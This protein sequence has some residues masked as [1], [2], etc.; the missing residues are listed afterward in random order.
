MAKN[1]IDD[2]KTLLELITILT[3]IHRTVVNCFG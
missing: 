2:I 1:N 3:E